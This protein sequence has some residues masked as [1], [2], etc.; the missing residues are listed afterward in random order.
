MWGIY[1]K[2]YYCELGLVETL[3]LSSSHIFL[4]VIWIFYFSAFAYH[5]SNHFYKLLNK[6]IEFQEF[7]LKFKKKK[8]LLIKGFCILIITAIIESFISI[9]IYNLIIEHF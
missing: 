7:K 4:E 5:I 8:Q 3:S 9:E 2:K 6:E 1:F